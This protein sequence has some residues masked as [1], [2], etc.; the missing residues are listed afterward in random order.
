MVTHHLSWPLTHFLS[1]LGFVLSVCEYLYFCYPCP[2]VCMRIAARS[3]HWMSSLITYF[4]WDIVAPSFGLTDWL[5][6][7]WVSKLQECAYMVAGGGGKPRPSCMRSTL[8]T[9]PS[10]L[11]QALILIRSPTLSLSKKTSFLPWSFSSENRYSSLCG[12]W[13]GHSPS[14]KKCQNH[15]CYKMRT[16]EEFLKIRLCLECCVLCLYKILRSALGRHPVDKHS[17]T[18][19]ELEYLHGAKT[20]KRP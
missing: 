14:A 6:D 9:K 15:R 7:Y 8:L 10:P 2:C 20:T 13:R 18:P 19:A 4:F 3:W 5:I 12:C 11:L 16:F 1:S 17:C